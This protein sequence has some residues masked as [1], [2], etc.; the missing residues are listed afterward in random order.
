LFQQKSVTTADHIANHIREEI[1]RGK[2][3]ADQ[4]LRQDKIASIHGM[5]TIPVREALFQLNGEGLIEFIPHRGAFV[6]TLSTQALTEICKIRTTL[7][8]LALENGIKNLTE[9][10]LD[11]ARKLMKEMKQQTDMVKWAEQNW[12]FHRTLWGS[13]DMPH[14]TQILRNL[15]ININR[16]LAKN[17]PTIEDRDYHDKHHKEH[18]NILEACIEG[19]SEIALIQLRRHLDNATELIISFNQEL[20]EKS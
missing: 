10:K 20:E 1:L 7:E 13:C 8:L 11:N 19:D 5:S 15:H 12:Q 2:L 17:V 16:Y 6:S 9:K 3:Q 4:V 18:T 14:L